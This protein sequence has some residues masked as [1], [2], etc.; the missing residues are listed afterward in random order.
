METTSAFLGVGL[1]SSG[2]VLL[3]ISLP[4]L[5]PKRTLGSPK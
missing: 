1:V 3:S 2:G 4:K 5:T